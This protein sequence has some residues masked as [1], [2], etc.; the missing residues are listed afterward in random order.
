MPSGLAPPALSGRW[1]GHLSPGIDALSARPDGTGLSE[2]SRAGRAAISGLSIDRVP[3]MGRHP[4]TRRQSRPALGS[5]R[6]PPAVP[7]PARRAGLAPPALSGRWAGHLSPGID[8]LSARPDGTG[9][10]G[11][12]RAGRAAISGLSIDRVPGMGRHPAT[13]RRSRSRH[14]IRPRASGN[15]GPALGACALRQFPVPHAIRPRAGNPGPA[16]GACAFQHSRPRAS[17][18]SR[19]RDAAR[20]HGPERPG[21]RLLSVT[22]AER[23]ACGALHLLS[24][25]RAERHS[26]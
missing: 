3:G 1:A 25:T 7:G 21:G 18:S 24:V 9:L 23:H 20:P 6:T 14:A 15:P 5:R 12:S 16:L 11:G 4:A 22:P 17:G 26:C 2:G 13:R 8:A 19:S 10:S